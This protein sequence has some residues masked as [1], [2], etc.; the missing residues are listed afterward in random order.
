L[1]LTTKISVLNYNLFIWHATFL[2]LATNFIDVGTIIPAMLIDAGGSS[3]HIGFMTA[4]MLGVSKVTQ[5]IFA[6]FLQNRNKKKGYL[7]LGINLRIFSLACIALLFVYSLVL[8]SSYIILIIFLLITIFSVSGSFANISYVDI[9]GKS[10][11]ESK[12]KS[13][14][15]MKQIISSIG[16]LIS[17]YF[18]RKILIT[19]SYP[20]NYT[21]LFFIAAFSLLIASLAFWRLKEIKAD[22]MKLYG[23]IN[24][25]KMIIKEIRDNKNLA[26]YLIIIN[27]L[28]ISITLLPFLVSYAKEILYVG[29]DEIGNYLLFKVIG[30]VIIGAVLFYFSKKISYKNMFYL[31]IILSVMI[32]VLLILLHSSWYFILFFTGGIIFALTQIA[33]S[34]VLL[35]VSSNHNRAFYTG[36][37]GAGSIIP[38]LFPIVGGW[39][40]EKFGYT[41]F[42]ILFI[43]VII[44]SLYF[45][46]HLNCKK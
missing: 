24:F 29:N 8:K 18:A 19:Y 5:L 21:L 10:V 31:I 44:T 35:E 46:Y 14:F 2:A 37:T 1:Q 26:N 34:G 3:M 15:S 7:L 13:F 11:L 20:K 27:T 16:I 38:A 39:I 30:S 41:A 23:I 9:L 43:T 6:P 33:N 40:I 36:L 25:T 45:V 32:P 17:A 4:I 42:F 28:G 12:R 22:G